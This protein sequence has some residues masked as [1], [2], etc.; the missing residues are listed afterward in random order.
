MIYPVY[1]AAGSEIHV[2]SKD[3]V[4]TI[5]HAQSK[6]NTSKNRR[7][8]TRMTGRDQKKQGTPRNGYN[9]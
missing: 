5:L 6:Q 2:V 3:L 1:G 7:S 4:Y 8:W 9:G